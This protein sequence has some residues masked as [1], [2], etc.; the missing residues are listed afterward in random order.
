MSFPIIRLPYLVFKMVLE[1]MGFIDLFILTRTSKKMKRY[2]KNYVKVRNYEMNV[3]FDT[4][5]ELNFTNKSNEKQVEVFV[6]ETIEKYKSEDEPK[7]F[8]LKLGNVDGINSGFYDSK[9]GEVPIL[10]TFWNDMTAG[11]EKFYNEIIEIFPDVPFKLLGIEHLEQYYG[12]IFQWAAGFTVEKVEM[13][14]EMVE[15]NHLKSL[16]ASIISLHAS[17]LSDQEIHDFL[18]ALSN[19]TSNTSL[20]ALDIS[21]YRNADCDFILE[22]LDVI[23]EEV[24]TRQDGSGPFEWSLMLDNGEFGTITYEEYESDDPERRC[25][26]FEVQIA[27]GKTFQ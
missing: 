19:N 7:C 6:V 16:D 26:G 1:S 13:T 8:P 14:G 20:K 24:P 17:T 3:D 27:R 25:W 10:G 4:H 2:V 23:Q 9:C 18:L 22:E 15:L 11:L 12:I 21:F 5:F